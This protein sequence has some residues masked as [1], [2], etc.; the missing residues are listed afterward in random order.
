[1]LDSTPPMQSRGTQMQFVAEIAADSASR[2]SGAM[3][4]SDVRHEVT[5]AVRRGIA[6]H[7]RRYEDP[8]RWKREWVSGFVMGMTAM[9]VG[10][11]CGVVVGVVLRILL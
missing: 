11:L 5:M 2:I 9:A 8:A 1:M 6:E 3:P 10:V 7:R 4:P